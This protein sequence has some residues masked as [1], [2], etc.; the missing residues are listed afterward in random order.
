MMDV[1]KPQLVWVDNRCYRFFDSDAWSDM[2]STAPYV[3]DNYP[4]DYQDEG[5]SDDDI[6]IVPHKSSQFKHEFHVAK[7]F[8]P[9]IIGSKHAIQKRIESE[10]KTA[11]VFPNVGQDRDIVITGYEK[12]GIR[13]ARR[14]IDMIIES[15]RKKIKPTH[16]LSVPLND[17]H[18]IMKFNEFKA[19]VLSLNARGIDNT[20]FQTPSKMHLTLG[21][22]LLLDDAERNL[23][24]EALDHCKEHIIKPIVE[25]YGKISLRIQGVDIMN[26]DSA[27]TRVL[28]GKISK[29]DEGLQEIANKT[30]EYFNGLGIASKWTG[31][32]KLHVT[33][34]N[35]KYKYSKEELPTKFTDTFDATEI[36]KAHKDTFFGEITMKQIHISQLH[37]I[38]SNG[39]YQATSKICLND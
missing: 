12:K 16:F 6:E 8:I 14:R 34:M 36:L 28:Y 35:I 13:T 39:Y 17:G 31:N 18:I 27:E 23:A 38:S 4:M 15:S 5:E 20:I 24:I 7:A 37:T 2:Q 3:E 11:M 26:D 19:H 30:M 21:M 22:L 32:I 33:L 9:F 1:L 29:S 10:T 25:K